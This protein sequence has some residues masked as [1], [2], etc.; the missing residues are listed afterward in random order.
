MVWNDFIE[1]TVLVTFCIVT[2]ILLFVVSVYAQS[3]T[4]ACATGP[5]GP[6]GADGPI[7]KIGPAAMTSTSY[8]HNNPLATSLVAPY[9]IPKLQSLPSVGIPYKTLVV[10]GDSAVFSW[11][12]MIDDNNAGTTTTQINFRIMSAATRKPFRTTN[13][14]QTIVLSWKRPDIVLGKDFNITASITRNSNESI[15]ITAMS[16]LQWT[17]TGSPIDN[18]LQ[19]VF[20]SDIN[21]IGENIFLEPEVN[22][23]I[24]STE[25]LFTICS[26]VNVFKV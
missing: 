23:P 2:Y 8:L 24:D 10:E 1:T 7:G 11:N 5:T 19:N 14:K 4:F 3:H 6:Q 26:S 25:K 9:P 15:I 13:N 21:F 20:C 17:M 22:I 12:F 18:A 16:G